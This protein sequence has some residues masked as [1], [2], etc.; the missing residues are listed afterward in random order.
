MLEQGITYNTT[1]GLVAGAIM[2]L[3]VVFA[4]AVQRP[5]RSSVDGWGWMFVSLGLVL[6]ITGT[7]MTLTWPLEQIPVEGV[8]CC[9]ADNVAFGEPAM[10]FGLLVVFAGIAL[11]RGERLAFERG[12]P[13]DVVS[14]VRPM[15]YAG[16]F[17]G[18]GLVLIGVA[19]VEFGMWG[20]P[21]PDEPI[22]RLMGESI[23]ERFYVAGAYIITGIAAMV[24]PFAPEHRIVG[25]I[26]AGATLVGGMMWTF[27]GIT[28][29]YGHIGFFPH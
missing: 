15:L 18:I 14:T 28:L 25:R 13:F 19:G 20:P 24:A 10:L 4:R 7:H 2:L 29:F 5:D 6:A 12:V 9:A 8:A 3:L 23:L 17:G 11:I 22:A 21:P 16:A 27:L 26:F 1:M